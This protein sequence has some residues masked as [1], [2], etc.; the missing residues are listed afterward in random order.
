M[1][2]LVGLIFFIGVLCV[3]I[4]AIMLCT[5]KIRSALRNR[6]EKNRVVNG[7]WQVLEDPDDTEDFMNFW[8]VKP[9]EPRKLLG[10]VP[11]NAA[12][13]EDRMI[14]ERVEASDKVRVMNRKD[15]ALF[16]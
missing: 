3:L 13:F 15:D 2:A 5:E 16:S 4:G 12:D 6:A 9:G 1:K 11:L 10:F 8:A 7:K 14:Q